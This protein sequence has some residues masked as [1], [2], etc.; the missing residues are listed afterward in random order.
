VKV[1]D[2]IARIDPE[3]FRMDEWVCGTAA[4]IGGWADLLMHHKSE[5]DADFDSPV[6]VS[7][8]SWWLGLTPNQ[9][10]E[11]FYPLTDNYRYTCGFPDQGAFITRD[12]AVRVIDHLIK[13]GEVDWELTTVS[14]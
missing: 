13:T 1:R 6:P 10:E 5:P 14:S 7:E 4:C 3:Q 8:I 2:K 11:L 12:H 9:K